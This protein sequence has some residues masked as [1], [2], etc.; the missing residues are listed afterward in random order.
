MAVLLIHASGGKAIRK[1]V[2]CDVP[3]KVTVAKAMRGKKKYV[4]L[5]EGLKTFGNS[6][7]CVC[8]VNTN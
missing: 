7:V 2:S 3:K 6:S 1:I 4:T 8:V 5:I